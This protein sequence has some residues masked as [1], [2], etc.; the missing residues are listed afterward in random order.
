MTTARDNLIE[1]MARTMDPLA[2]EGR[3]SAFLGRGDELEREAIARCG[4]ALRNASV[5]LVAIEATG[6]G[7]VPTEPTDAML[8]A[9]S[10]DGS[11]K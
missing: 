11:A 5:A 2:F 3:D 7:I 9:R 4:V 6:Y 10:R 1:A 8:A